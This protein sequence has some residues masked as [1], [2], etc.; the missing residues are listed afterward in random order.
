MTMEFSA[1][2]QYGVDV[3]CVGPDGVLEL[4]RSDRVSVYYVRRELRALSHADRERFLD[5]FKLL[6]EVSTSE[7]KQLYG[8]HYHSLDY[9]VTAHL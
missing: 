1:P 3:S 8:E 5:A 6:G 2:G 4:Q 7:G 9:F